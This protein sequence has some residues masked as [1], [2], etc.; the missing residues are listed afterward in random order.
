MDSTNG[1]TLI[2]ND[3][4]ELLPRSGFLFDG[5]TLSFVNDLFALNEKKTGWKTGS[6]SDVLV[7]LYRESNYKEVQVDYDI[8][9][10]DHVVDTGISGNTASFEIWNRTDNQK[11]KFVIVEQSNTNNGIWD[12]GETIFI[13]EMGLP[14]MTS[15]GR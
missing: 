1:D 13:L 11:S 2:L 4:I 5:I 8:L 10:F 7:S 15:I 14:P 6:Q 12:L 3:E 9:F